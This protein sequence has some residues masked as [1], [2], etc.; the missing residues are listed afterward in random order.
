MSPTE[1]TILFIEDDPDQQKMYSFIFKKAGFKVF[2]ALSG[3]EGIKIAEKEHPRVIVLDIL[4]N[5]K[6]GIQT[7]ELIKKNTAIPKETS[8]IM[9]SNYT[10]EEVLQKARDLG[11]DE[12]IIKTDIAPHEFVE[13]INRK[14]FNA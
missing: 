3:E 12:I 8:V 14:Y 7:L 11:A 5:T 4:M 9:F 1:K 2:Q 13:R 6:N 10:K